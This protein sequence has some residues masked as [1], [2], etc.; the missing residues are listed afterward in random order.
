ML[1]IFNKEFK[2][3]FHSYIGYIFLIVFLLISG[4]LFT[5]SNLLPGNGFYNDLIYSMNYIFLFLAPLL[6]MKLISNETHERTDQLLFTSPVK[7]WEIVLGKFL[8]ASAIF[9]IAVIITFAYPL[10]LSHFG[11]IPAGEIIGAYIGFILMGMCFISIGLFVSSLTDNQVTAAFGTFGALFFI[12]LIDWL[13][14]ALPTSV[15]SGIIFCVLL[16]LFICLIIYN[17]TNNIYLSICFGVLSSVIIL[18]I[19]FV[20]K[21]IYD[22]LIVNFFGWFSLLKRYEPFNIG[23]LNLSSIVYYITFCIT[24]IF[25]TIKTIDKRRWN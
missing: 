8:A 18:A 10:I 6:T 16:V 13:T 21:S 3:Y 23:M 22:S 17:N 1:T 4:L 11:T 25:L 2:S 20:N 15:I 5:L 12:W 9:L 24:F 7:L 14:S 19:Y